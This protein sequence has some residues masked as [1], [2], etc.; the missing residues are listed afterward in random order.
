MFL[1]S[2]VAWFLLLKENL[3]KSPSYEKKPFLFFL[4]INRSISY[5]KH[6]VTKLEKS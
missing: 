4:F 6:A 3:L 2:Q 1:D 5:I